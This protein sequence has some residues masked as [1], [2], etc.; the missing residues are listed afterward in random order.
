MK[1][2]ILENFKKRP[3]S[4]KIS[5]KTRTA[6]DQGASCYEGN[7]LV[8]DGQLFTYHNGAFIGIG[9]YLNS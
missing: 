6:V 4:A 8:C 1:I 9:G 3:K 5:L 7:V 2:R